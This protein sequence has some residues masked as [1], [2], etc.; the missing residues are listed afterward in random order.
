MRER[1]NKVKL[2]IKNNKGFSIAE[3]LIAFALLS[4]VAICVFGAVTAG[5]NMFTRVDNDINIQFKSQTAMTQFQEQ[6]MSC[7]TAITKMDGNVIYFSD[8][9][10]VYA[11]RYD[12]DESKIYFGSSPI[13]GAKAN[14][15]SNIT[16]PL[17]SDVSGFNVT[18]NTT[19][20]DIAGSVKVNLTITSG[21]KSYPTSQIFTFR[22]RPV[23]IKD[24]AE[25]G[26]YLN[27][28]VDTITA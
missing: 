19:S 27:A 18:V 2:N 9:E 10:K 4:V 7:S 3:M 23:Y 26:S 13:S 6:F 17:C 25:D 1:L 12:E 24:A 8:S 21:G 28:L 15:P 5:G 16:A 20:S 11:L 22:N 14:L